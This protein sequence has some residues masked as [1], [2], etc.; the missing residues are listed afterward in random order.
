MEST[1]GLIWLSTREHLERFQEIREA[2]PWYRVFLGEVKLPLLA[3]RRRSYLG[4]SVARYALPAPE[5]QTPR[6]AARRRSRQEG[7]CY[8]AFAFA[9]GRPLGVLRRGVVVRGGV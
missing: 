2:T 7:L 5:S 4:S 1:F 8:S 9:Q 6:S 3:V